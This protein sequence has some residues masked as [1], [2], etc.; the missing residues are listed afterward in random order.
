MS[1]ETLDALSRKIDNIRKIQ[2]GA[3]KESQD[4]KR[5]RESSEKS[6]KA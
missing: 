6:G 1:K 5:S 2:A 4:L 3:K